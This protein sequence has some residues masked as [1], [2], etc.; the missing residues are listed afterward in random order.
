MKRYIELKNWNR[1]EHF[2]LF[3]SYASPFWGVSANIDCTR[4]LERSKDEKFSFS[5][6]YHYASLQALNRIES[7][8]QRFEHGRIIEYERVHLSSTIGRPDGTFGFNFVRFSED[9]EV[10]KSDWQKETERITGSDVLSCGYENDDVVFYSVLRGV[11][12]TSCYHPFKSSGSCIP[13]VTF[14]ETFKEGIRLKIPHALQVHHAFIDG[15]H[16][17]AYFNLVQEFLNE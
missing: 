7:F 10:F 11:S 14:G 6:G 15:H 4:L 5:T 8:R 9:F 3:A 17:K 1:R 12:F 16:A 2:E 13:I